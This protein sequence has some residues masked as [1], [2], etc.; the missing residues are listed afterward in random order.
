M[1]VTDEVDDAL[2]LGLLREQRPDLAGLELR[3]VGRGWDNELWRLGGELAVRLPRTDRAPDLLRKQ[4]RWLP[5]FAP[6]LPLPVPTPVYL[7]EACTLFPQ[8]W[9]IVAWVHGDPADRAQVESESSARVLA[10]F[11]GALHREE[12]PTAERYG[13]AR[14]VLRNSHCDFGEDL[15]GVVGEDRAWELEMIWQD[16]VSAP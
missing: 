11:L 13:E 6:R 4:H 5:V 2:V 3:R 8:P 15:I 9:A 16:A 12:L 10:E 7:G 14:R 1:D